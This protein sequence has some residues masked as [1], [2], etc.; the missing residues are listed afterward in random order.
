[1]AATRRLLYTLARLIGDVM[2]YRR[3]LRAAEAPRQLEITRARVYAILRPD[4]APPA[5][6]GRGRDGR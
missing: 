3:A 6:Q 2:R 5:L 1:M 4:A